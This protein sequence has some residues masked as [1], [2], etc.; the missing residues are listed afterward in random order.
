LSEYKE[1]E[2][3]MGKSGAESFNVKYYKGLGT[4]TAREAK[5]YFSDLH[6]H[7]I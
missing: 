3:K 6:K 1:W 7:V 2:E 5:E 4:S